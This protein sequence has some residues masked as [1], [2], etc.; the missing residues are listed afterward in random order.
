M[1][2][3]GLGAVAVLM[4]AAALVVADVESGPKAGETVGPLKVFAVT[5]SIEGKEVDYAA[6]RKGAPT[7]YLFVNAEKFSRPVARFLKTLDGKLGD[8]NDNAE[9]VAVWVGGDAD[10]N[11][12]YLPRAQ[13][14][15]KL[16]KTALTA[17]TGDAGGPNGWGINSDAHLTVV[18]TNK[19][20][21]VKSFAFVSVNATDVRP[22]LAA[23]QKAVGK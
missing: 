18:L 21:V 22:V 11:K 1:T 8:V 17:F 7:V 6:E 10:K 16:N 20:K 2:A 15:L 5:G 12:E 13:M 4:L 23:F 19:G 9:A 14:S 3:R